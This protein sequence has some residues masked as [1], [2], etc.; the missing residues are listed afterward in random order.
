MEPTF[1]IDRW[2]EGRIGFHEGAPNALLAKHHPRLVGPRVLVPLC[3]KAEDL[4]FL[5][6]HGHEVIGI[7]LVED[8]VRAFFAEHA[9]TPEVR[10][11]GATTAYTADAI[12]ILAGDFFAVE[13][14]DV[15]AIDEIYDRAALIALPPDMRRQYAYRVYA[16]MPPGT[17]ALVVDL[18]YPQ[19]EKQGPPF[20]VDAAEMRA[21]F[22]E[23]W[24][25]DLLERRDILADQPSFQ[26]EG[27]TALHTSAWR[28]LKR[29]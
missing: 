3:G 11:Q 23:R 26:A 29:T 7:E 25:V 15:G 6:H 8:A 16:R 14:A 1:W 24:A 19:E 21:L 18:E 4:A 12:T 28:L 5:A 9:L 10:R 27:L 22:G 17:R 20:S 13:P 2:R